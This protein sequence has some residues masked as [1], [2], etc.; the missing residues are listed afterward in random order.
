MLGCSWIGT[1]DS[2][3]LCDAV[4]RKR[5]MN[6]VQW[7]FSRRNTK[8]FESFVW[9]SRSP[10]MTRYLTLSWHWAIWRGFWSAL[11]I[12]V[13]ATWPV[14]VPFCLT[15]MRP[16][17]VCFCLTWTLCKE[18]GKLF[19]VKKCETGGR[20]NLWTKLGAE[21][22]DSPLRLERAFCYSLALSWSERKGRAPVCHGQENQDPKTKSLTLK[23]FK[24]PIFTSKRFPLGIWVKQG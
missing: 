23:A 12:F 22:P 14:L 19:L 13:A 3:L 15:Q 18:I 6:S 16:K 10:D 5:W 1:V 17:T 9:D 20:E 21:L 24:L 11:Q 2:F 8:H 4:T 7:V